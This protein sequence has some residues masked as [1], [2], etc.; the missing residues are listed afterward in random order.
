MPAL[1]GGFGNYLLPVQV[2]APDMA[3]TKFFNLFQIP[4][5]DVKPLSLVRKYSTGSNSHKPQ[6]SPKI[7]NTEQYL[8]HYLAGLIEGD[9]Y[10]S[11]TSEDRVIL[12]ITF[13]LK[14]KPLAEKLL[15]YLGKGSIA[16]RKTNCI[17]LR[18]SPPDT[19]KLYVK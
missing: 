7:N 5:V 17:E 4:R 10:I 11:I 16:K 15:S 14:D 13:N 8:A 19:N 3:N 2:G 12:G 1:V 6:L 18:F 9:G